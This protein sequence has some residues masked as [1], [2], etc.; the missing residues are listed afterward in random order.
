MDA[1]RAELIGRRAKVVDAKNKSLI[2]ISG[3]ISDETRNMLFIKGA[4]GTK[5]LIKGECTLSVEIDGREFIIEGMKIAKRPED[6]V[7]M[8][9]RD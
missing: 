1:V 3:K 9:I 4:K 5:S 7:G 2:G 6:R 8:K